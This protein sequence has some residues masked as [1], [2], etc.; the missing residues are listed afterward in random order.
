MLTLVVEWRARA[1]WMTGKRRVKVNRGL[2]WWTALGYAVCAFLLYAALHIALGG[3]L[4][5]E[6]SS[7]GATIVYT[8]MTLAVLLLFLNPMVTIAAGLSLDWLPRFVLAVPFSKPARVLRQRERDQEWAKGVFRQVRSKR[9][10]A[11][12]DLAAAY[13]E[14][15]QR[16]PVRGP[17]LSFKSRALLARYERDLLA[18][19]QFID[20][21]KHETNDI[22][23]DYA[24]SNA[25]LREK[26][27]AYLNENFDVRARVREHLH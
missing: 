12:S 22:E 17:A 21:W 15:Y 5:G 18:A 13:V 24:A 25:S 20:D 3:V 11:R 10:S 8:T 4:E 6:L 26:L 27:D 1:R 16:L 23:A 2:R 9:L 19:R 14:L 7:T